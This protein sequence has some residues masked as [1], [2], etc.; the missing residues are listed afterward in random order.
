MPIS[1]KPTLNA[2]CLTKVILKT[3][4][5]YCPV[6]H[7]PHLVPKPQALPAQATQQETYVPKTVEIRKH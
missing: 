3:L 4:Q 2:M 7:P 1:F 5:M 6:L